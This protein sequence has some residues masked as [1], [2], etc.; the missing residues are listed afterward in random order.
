MNANILKAVAV[1]A[2]LTGA[3]LSEAALRIMSSDLSAYPEAGVVRALERCRRELKA[4][5]TLAAVLERIEEEDGRPGSDEA[6]AIAISAQDEAETVV[7]TEE[8]AQA[9]A[10]A[11][12]ILEAREKVGARMAFLDAYE[13]IAREGRASGKPVRWTVSIGH[14]PERRATAL[15]AAVALRRI[16]AADIHGLLPDHSGESAV[17]PALLTQDPRPLLEAPMGEQERD[18]CRKGLQGVL[19]HL[20]AL[21]ARDQDR[22]E[23]T[24]RAAERLHRERQQQREQAVA[25]VAQYAASHGIDLGREQ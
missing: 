7:W 24:Q 13:R 4:R 20:K 9:F 10:V 8:I 14:D 3:E 16:E 6:W 22:T 21:E 23:E 18:H 12:P 1:T 2:E 19:A 17:V 25:R 11:Q 5:L 15:S